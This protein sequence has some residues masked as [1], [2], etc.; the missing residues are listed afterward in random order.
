MPRTK[1]SKNKNINT[2]KNK[3]VININVNSSTSKKGRGRPRKQSN[4]TTQNRQTRHPLGY[5]PGPSM[6]APPQVI[7]SQPTP[8]QDNSLLSS[9]ITSRMLNESN[10][11]S[12][13]TNIPTVEPPTTRE[14]P[15][16]FN[17]RESIIPKLPDTPITKPPVIKP[18]DISPSTKIKTGE[19]A[20]PP[21]PTKTDVKP[22]DVAP[23]KEK[24]PLK[25]Y[26]KL[27]SAAGTVADAAASDIGIS[28][29][30][31]A[32][33]E[34]DK[35]HVASTL[36]GSALRGHRG[37]KTHAFIKK[38]PEIVN[39]RLEDVKRMDP[40]TELTYKPVGKDEKPE[41]PAYLQFL[42]KKREKDQAKLNKAL[43]ANPIIGQDLANIETPIQKKAARQIQAALR[44]KIAKNEYSEKKEQT[45]AA[46]DIQTAIRQ[47]IAKNKVADKYLEKQK[48][49][50]AKT[51]LSEAVKR[52]AAYQ[53]VKNIIEDPA[54]KI[55]STFR[56]Y[57][58]R[59]ALAG[60]KDFQN[61]INMKIKQY[62]D[63]A[64]DLKTRGS[65]AKGINKEFS[66]VVKTMRTGLQKYKTTVG[67]QA[68][69]RGRP[70]NAP[71][72][73]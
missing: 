26:K 67:I 25:F 46:T 47:K 68:K 49:Q 29:I 61:K 37:R 44:Q 1:G 70:K 16:Y 45:N 18:A 41:K 62:S 36:I 33:N 10:M 17:A 52:K 51:T 7:V 22:D 11:L 31:S 34:I 9:F 63:A 2:A 59:S 23:P 24:G 13:R 57:R 66:D 53:K 71:L 15:S 38:Y 72:E 20:P 50:Q 35:S 48:E 21:E 58:T 39:K 30:E 40:R 5:N 42:E 65:D 73:F 32:V 28:I 6:M 14:Q 55:Q 3:N 56:G 12:S 19:P 60:D 43:L 69:K 64:S 27:K 4:D 54:K 8:Q